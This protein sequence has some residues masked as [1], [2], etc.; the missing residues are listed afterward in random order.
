M[1]PWNKGKTGI[2]S[3]DALRRMS[4]TSR[5]V[6]KGK[7][8]LGIQMSKKT[9][10]KLSIIAKSRIG[11]RASN[12]KGGIS[13]D[14]GIYNAKRKAL[15]LKNGGMFTALEWRALKEKYQNHCVA[16][17]RQEPE[18]QLTID[19]IVPLI[20]GGRN[21]IQNIQPLCQSCNSKK[22]TKEVNFLLKFV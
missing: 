8:M 4:E 1:T 12:W 21:D 6:G 2:Y 15:K 11:S 5:K 16:C 22:H 10:Q 3:A 20:L 18:I 19:H 13:K 7:N 9:K 14:W 17:F